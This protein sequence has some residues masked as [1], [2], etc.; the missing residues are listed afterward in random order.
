MPS[1]TFRIAVSPDCGYSK[2]RG[3]LQI[4]F[5]KSLL[6]SLLITCQVAAEFLFQGGSGLYSCWFDSA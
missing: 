2:G 3:S 6:K 5:T 1:G 4:S